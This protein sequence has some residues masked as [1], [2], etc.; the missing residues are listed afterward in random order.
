MSV[1]AEAAYRDVP[2][3][4]ERA[5]DVLGDRW[6]LLILRAATTGETRFDRFRAELGIADNILAARLARLV[7]AGL[8]TKVPYRDGG[9]TRHEYV[10]T[11]AGA[12]ALP[13][14]LAM[15]RWG[16]RHTRTTDPSGPMRVLHSVC[17]QALA[18]GEYC[19]HCG[20][21]VTRD[22]TVWIRPWRSPEP[23]AMARPAGT[24]QGVADTDGAA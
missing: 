2:C 20:R 12:D 18:S 1:A 24:A 7:A 14:L 22:E 13:V 21:L 3:P 15:A 6:T 10:L 23:V 19:A 5:A 16:E 9:R 17:G 4:I 11:P 8:L